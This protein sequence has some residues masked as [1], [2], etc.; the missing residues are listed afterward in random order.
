MD[1][2]RIGAVNSDALSV[3]LIAVSYF[4]IHGRTLSRPDL[5][6]PNGQRFSSSCRR[7]WERWPGSHAQRRGKLQL[8]A[9]NRA[10]RSALQRRSNG[11]TLRPSISSIASPWTADGKRRKRSGWTWSC[12]SGD[13]GENQR[14]YLSRWAFLWWTHGNHALCAQA[15]TIAY[16]TLSRATYAGAFRPWHA[17]SIWIN[18][19][20]GVGTSAD[21]RRNETCLN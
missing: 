4:L 20:D 19:R 17:R 9:A 3:R 8:S 10:C 7:F 14:S 16:R 5:R 11:S 13:T 6:S 12:C 1:A 2:G 21:S 15:G 18:T